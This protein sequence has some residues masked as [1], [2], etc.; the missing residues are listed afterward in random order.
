MYD[1][2]I[3]KSASS[4][5]CHEVHD[6]H[7]FLPALG[8]RRQAAADADFKRTHAYTTSQTPISNYYQIMILYLAHVIEQ[9]IF[10]IPNLEYLQQNFVNLL[11]QQ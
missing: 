1:D 10:R 5:I 8:A 2:I 4:Y 9:P 6:S 3:V 11:D 7:R